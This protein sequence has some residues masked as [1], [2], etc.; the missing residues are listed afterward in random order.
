VALPR[1][2]RES[3]SKVVSGV[4]PVLSWIGAGAAYA[5]VYNVQGAIVV[6]YHSVASPE[7]EPFVSPS[8]SVPAATFEA[9]M[10]YLA[11]NRRVVPMDDIVNALAARRTLPLGTVA[12]TFDDGYRDT[13]EIAAPILAKHELPATLY[14]ATGYVE[15]GENQWIDEL[16]AMF[17]SRR[18]HELVLSRPGPTTHAYDLSRPAEMARARAA[19]NEI[20][21]SLSA[22]E[23][24][25]LLDEIAAQL[26]PTRRLPRLTLSWPEAKAL[27]GR[28]RNIAIGSHTRDHTD[29]STCDAATRDREIT[30][31]IADVGANLGLGV[32]HFTYPYGRA[33]RD[34]EKLLGGLGL[35]SACVTEPARPIDAS[36]SRY[37]IMRFEA[38]RDMSL[39]RLLVS[40]VHSRFPRRWTAA[41][42]V[43]A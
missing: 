11:R 23:R 21:I 28:Y 14:L 39:F 41:P 29:L 1:F 19:L 22:A 18:D 37:A 15:R 42:A 12:L 24:R 6:M 40:G 26:R 8:I 13:L 2:A 4:R 20:L 43:D 30:S 16:H 3:M 9:Q 27:V 33:M 35:R 17:V 25:A 34:G 7:Q 36:T 5:R 31:S 38:P 10:R 32:S